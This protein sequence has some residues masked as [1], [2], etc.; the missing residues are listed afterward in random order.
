VALTW[1]DV[2]QLI[3][4][5][6][7]A[8]RVAAVAHEANRNT[9]AV[10]GDRALGQVLDELADEVQGVLQG[11]DRNLAEEFDRVVV[12]MMP[13]SWSLALRA[14]ILTGWLE[15]AVEAETL[16]VRIRVGDARP[17]SRKAPSSSAAAR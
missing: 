6:A 12:D 10:L 5:Q 4:L 15:G 8:R 17:R 16:E 13:G 14:S 7:V 9:P 2:K 11:A 3:R 1:G